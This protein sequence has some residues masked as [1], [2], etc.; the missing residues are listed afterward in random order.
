M[1][2]VNCK[3]MGKIR[4]GGYI[5]TWWKGDHEPRHVHV[6]MTNGQKLGRLDITAMRGLEGWLP[7]RKLVVVIE[8]LKNE[9]RL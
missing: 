8:E 7:D 4:R 6:K 1:R 9:G 2:H 5:I 3:I